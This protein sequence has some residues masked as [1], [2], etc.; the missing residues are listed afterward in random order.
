LEIVKEA[1]LAFEF[2]IKLFEELDSKY[3]KNP[4]PKIFKSQTEEIPAVPGN[5]NFNL[6]FEIVTIFILIY[7][8]F[9]MK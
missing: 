3:F 9:F 2:N 1:N 4:E 7:Y 6:I 5:F 8:F